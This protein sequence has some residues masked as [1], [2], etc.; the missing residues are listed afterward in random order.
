MAATDNNALEA[1]L[2]DVLAGVLDKARTQEQS[3]DPDAALATLEQ[4]PAPTHTIGTY[5]YARGAL[6]VRKGRLDEGIEALQKAVDL[7]PEIAEMKSNL[8]A[9]YLE[10]VQRH[11]P[12]GLSSDPAQ[13]DLDQALA[14]LSAAATEHPKL[15]EVYANHGRALTLAGR[16]PEALL[17]FDRALALD[18]THLPALYNKAAALAAANRDQECLAVLDDLL[19]VAPDFAAAKQSRQ[20]VRERLGAA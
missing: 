19:R 16:I 6:L 17:A 2:A 12:D 20:R 5:H 18:G 8:G 7:E 3:G 11:G 10:R 13:Q 15:P 14:L 1:E 4:A 9:A